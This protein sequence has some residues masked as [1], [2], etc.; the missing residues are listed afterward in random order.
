MVKCIFYCII[1]TILKNSGDSGSGVDGRL[2]YHDMNPATC[3]H[4]SFEREWCRS[5]V[6][7]SYT[8]VIVVVHCCGSPLLAV[9]H[10]KG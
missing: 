4:V 2:L 5:I 7:G 6:F 1:F 8:T 10:V 3:T 9:C